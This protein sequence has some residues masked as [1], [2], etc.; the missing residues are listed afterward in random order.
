MKKILVLAAIAATSWLYAGE[1]IILK[2]ELQDTEPKY[3]LSADG[4][5][6]GLCIEL[7]N[8][9]ESN[10]DYK[11][12]YEKKFIPKKRL[13]Q[14]LENGD[15][16]IHFGLARNADREKVVAYVEEP[17]YEVS[18]MLIANADDKS[19]D[20]KSKDEL[21]ASA[22]TEQILAIPGTSQSE[23]LKKMGITPNEGS[24][25]VDENL[26]KLVVK[27]GRMLMY[28]DLGLFFHMNTP[29]F[30]NKFKVLSMDFGKK[31]TGWLYQKNQAK[32]VSW[33]N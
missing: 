11:F 16:D 1:K 14:G 33:I 28:Y 25:A 6:T 29:E 5:A 32:S 17:L 15:T 2:T 27:R 7:M 9:I 22:K 8:L 13:E 21:L 10:S 4:K 12:E 3:I 26:R 19:F 24:P 18:D 20:I 30:K 23:T 31:V